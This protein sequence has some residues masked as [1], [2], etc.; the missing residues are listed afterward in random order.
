MQPDGT[1]MEIAPLLPANAEQD[2]A[3]AFLEL[4]RATSADHR[5]ARH[6]ADVGE[7]MFSVSLQVDDLA[8]AVRDLR[9]KSIDVSAPEPGVLPNTIVARIP[10]ARAHGVAVQLIERR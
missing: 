8:A 5:I 1:H 10:R 3:G 7:G 4:V 6:V 2:G 9:A